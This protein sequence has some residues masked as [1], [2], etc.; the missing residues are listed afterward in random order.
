MLWVD[1]QI[2]NQDWENKRH[3]E[4]AS[5]AGVHINVH[6]ISKASTETALAFLESPFGKRLKN[7][8]TFRIVTDMKRLNEDKP[9]NAGA[10]LL[11]EVRKMGFNCDCL[12]FT[13]DAKEANKQLDLVFDGKL[14]RKVIKV[15]TSPSDLEE[16][17]NFGKFHPSPESLCLPS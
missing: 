10:R 6:F 3:M 8:E 12:V 16:F 14:D 4:K 17:V 15:T 11:T 5:T 1:D 7:K 13:S 9:D 2:F